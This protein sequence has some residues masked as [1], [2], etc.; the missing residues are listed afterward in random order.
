MKS[1]ILK[2]LPALTA[3]T[4]ILFTAVVFAGCDDDDDSDKDSNVSVVEDGGT[5]SG[6]FTKDV[7]VEKDAKITLKGAVIFQS[8][9]TLKINEGVTVKASVET[10]SYLIIARGA[11]I[12]AIGTAK[13]PITFTSSKPDGTR[14]ASDWG[15]III[16]GKAKINQGG[17]EAEGEGDSGVYGGTDDADNSGTLKYV[18]VFFAGYPF[19][20]TNELN[21][22]CLQGVGSGTSIEYLQIHSGSDDGIEMF[23]GTV[24]LKYVMS[25]ANEDDQ[26]DCTF[27]W[28]GTIE[29]AVAASI[30][31]DAA[32][33]Y[34]NNESNFQAEPRTSVKHK[35][36][37]V[38]AREALDSTNAMKS[39]KGA[40][41]R[42]GTNAWFE[43]SYFVQVGSASD[44]ILI[45][46]NSGSIVNVSNS[47]F[48]NAKTVGYKV[49]KDSKITTDVNGTVTA[50][51]YTVSPSA[52]DLTPF[53]ST[54]A[55]AAKGADAFV[56]TTNGAIT[57]ANNNWAK[58]WTEFPAN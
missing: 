28:R 53:A 47:Y 51:A 2:K 29:Y 25:T 26:I 54:A 33:E 41:M 55:L 18:R 37:T 22:V 24:N 17:G 39:N 48:Q 9:S 5:L 13:K 7:E 44:D 50:S 49:S 19:S 4:A 42:R 6:V 30:Q 10:L 16:N 1:S 8:G 34:D 23:G 14:K 58:G 27:G 45:S 40:R 32:M 38:I 12:E 20:S 21:G 52:M 31:G 3:M 57:D 46:E 11:K 56:T 36:I 43:N 35:Y 15:G